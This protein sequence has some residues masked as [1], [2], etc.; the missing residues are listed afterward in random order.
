MTV[1][2]W[3]KERKKEKGQVWMNI[4]KNT[5][6]ICRRFVKNESWEGNSVKLANTGM[7]LFFLK[8]RILLIAVYFYYPKYTAEKLAAGLSLLKG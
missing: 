5:Y 1:P 7:Y 4:K 6:K 8:K 3:E 2:E